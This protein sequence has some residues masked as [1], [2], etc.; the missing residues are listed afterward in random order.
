MASLHIRS[1]IFEHSIYPMQSKFTQ[2]TLI[3]VFKS[4]HMLSSFD[5]KIS[6]D[7]WIE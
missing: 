1:E 5:Y 6:M 4:L 3:D 7:N 2:K